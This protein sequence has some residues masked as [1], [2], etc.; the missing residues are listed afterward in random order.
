MN[1]REALQVL[2]SMPAVERIA[3]VDVTP[4]SVIVL[5]VPGALTQEHAARL[6]EQLQRVWPRHLVVVLPEGMRIKVL[7]GQ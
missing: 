1:R 3:R 6:H 4:S 7:D 2:V 5:E